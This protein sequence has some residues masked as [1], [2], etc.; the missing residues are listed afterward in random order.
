MHILENIQQLFKMMM[1]TRHSTEHKQS[2][3]LS[4]KNNNKLIGYHLHKKEMLHFKIQFRLFFNVI[5]LLK[6]HGRL[7]SDELQPGSVDA[8]QPT[9]ICHFK[10]HASQRE[11]RLCWYLEKHTVDVFQ[12]T[13][14][15]KE[16]RWIDKWRASTKK[17]SFFELLWMT[18]QFK[19]VRLRRNW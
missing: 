10:E 8:E 6:F 12:A 11:S 18:E 4:V 5:Q 7:C 13:K 3:V 19:N 15:I 9:V 14:V 17:G 1:M 2:W 16:V